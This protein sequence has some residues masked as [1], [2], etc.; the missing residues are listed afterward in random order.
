MN[1][2]RTY[3]TKQQNAILDFF[4]EHPETCYTAGQLL[5]ALSETGIG[6]ATIYRSLQKLTASGLIKK[7]APATGSARED[8]RLNRACYQYTGEQNKC[9]DHF[10]LKC[11][12][13]GS[14]IHM[15]CGFMDEI[16][17][18]IA[19]EHHF[20]VDNSQTTLYGLCGKCAG[21]VKAAGEGK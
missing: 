1:S 12:S 3:N 2:K 16:N 13:C 17:R 21:L 20:T 6:E 11:L 15:D 4:R 10:H 9:R 8:S 7:F 19:E 5:A 14:V 18:H